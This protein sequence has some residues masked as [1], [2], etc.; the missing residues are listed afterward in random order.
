MAFLGKVSHSTARYRTCLIKCPTILG[1]SSPLGAQKR[2]MQW[3]LESLRRHPGGFPSSSFQE[4]KVTDEYGNIWWRKKTSFLIFITLSPIGNTEVRACPFPGPKEGPLS[5]GYLFF[6]PLYSLNLVLY[7]W[8]SLSF[9]F[10]LGIY[11][12]TFPIWTFCEPFSLKAGLGFLD[13]GRL[14]D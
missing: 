7:I 4:P 14:C 8:N 1:S 11:K 10:Q 9:L 3:W 2:G 6:R 12:N 13:L 5:K